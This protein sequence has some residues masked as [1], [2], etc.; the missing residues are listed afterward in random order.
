M[1]TKDR[2]LELR[3]I[4]R[5]HKRRAAM[6]N[7]MGQIQEIREKQENKNYKFGVWAKLGRTVMSSQV[8]KSNCRKRSR[9]ERKAG[10]C[11]GHT[12]SK[13]KRRHLG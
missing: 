10:F 9:H 13:E 4:A 12:E 11:F 2:S 8:E 7:G 1:G 6:R 5:Q 3:L